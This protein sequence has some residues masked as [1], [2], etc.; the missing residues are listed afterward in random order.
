[1]TATGDSKRRDL[2][3]GTFL[4]TG[5]GR[6]LGFAIA[7]ALL[8]RGAQVVC[9]AW[10]SFEGLAEKLVDHGSRAFAVRADLRDPKAPTEIFRRVEQW[11]LEIEGIVHAA[12]PFSKATL[13]ETTSQL[14]DETFAVEVRAPV[15]L[16]KELLRHRAKK[17]GAMVLLADTS[18]YASWQCHFAHSVAKSCIL[19][20]VRALAREMAP[21]YRVNALILGS[22][23]PPEATSAEEMV[24][25][26]ERTLL[27][28]L[29]QPQDAID[30]VIYLLKAPYVTGAWLDV[31]GGAPW[32]RG[33]GGELQPEEGKAHERRTKG[34][35]L[36]GPT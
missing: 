33:G 20:L 22:V 28:K 24:R 7:E 29:G 2:S 1:M 18:V 3:E 15:L 35:A 10:S 14:W 4:V 34:S 12:S 31:H 19:S 8:A 17:G 16:A 5:A 30:A 36:G 32:G 21:H 26:R 13:E 25:M 27:K 9:H 11:G 6:R 23:L